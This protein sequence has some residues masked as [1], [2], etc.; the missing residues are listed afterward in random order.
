MKSR[1]GALARSFLIWLSAIPVSAIAHHGISAQFDNQGD[2]EIEGVISDITWRNPHVL[3]D[4]MATNEDGQ[5][6]L[7]NVETLSMSMMRKNEISRDRLRIGDQVRIAGLPSVRGR[8][9]IYVTNL[10]LPGGEEI[11]FN[12]RVE[13]RWSDQV[14]GKSGPNYAQ[15]GDTSAPELGIFRAWSSTSATP[16]YY[17]SLNFDNNPLAARPPSRRIRR[18][19]HREPGRQPV[20]LHHDHYRR[21]D[22][23]RAGR[24]AEVLAFRARRYRTNLRVHSR[25]GAALY[26]MTSA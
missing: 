23:R 19:F 16:A 9:E 24:T 15:E 13:P 26:V 6:V 12:A 5:E 10:L 22:A 8:N 14:V 25:L 2:A 21:V 4:V 18:A 1:F 11:V 7:W 17:S 20:K 3:F